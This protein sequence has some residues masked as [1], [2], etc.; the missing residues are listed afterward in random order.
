MIVLTATLVHFIQ[1]FIT[2]C[3]KIIFHIIM[4]WLRGCPT[5]TGRTT[6][7]R[8]EEKVK[9]STRQSPRKRTETRGGKKKRPAREKRAYQT[10]EQPTALPKFIDDDARERFEWISHKGL[11]TQRTI[12]PSEFRKLDLEPVIKLFEF[13]KWSHILSLS[14]TYNLDMLYQ[15]FANLRKGSSHTELVSRVNSIDIALTPDIV[16]MVLKTKIEDGFKGKIASFFSYEEFPIAYHH[17]HI[18][19]LMTYFQKHFN[20]PVKQNW[21]ILV[22]KI[23]SSLQ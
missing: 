1:T 20:T 16:N 18:E 10:E 19:K 4:V 3:N 7:I 17:F 2:L 5:S 13:Q 12:V 8:D 21:R 6:R 9:P 22:L 15:F 14:N 23:W 11:I